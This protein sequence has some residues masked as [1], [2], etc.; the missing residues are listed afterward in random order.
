MF[1]PAPLPVAALDDRGRLACLRLIRSENVGPV[2]FR[3]LVNHCGGAE[4]ALAALPELSR[5]GGGGA[6]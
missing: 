2:T 4:A 6:F 1:T 5:R 3:E